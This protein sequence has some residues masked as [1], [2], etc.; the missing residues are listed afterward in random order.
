[1][2]SRLYGLFEEALGKP[3][4]EATWQEVV[5]VRPQVHAMIAE[6]AESI[7]LVKTHNLLGHIMEVPTINLPVSAGSIYVVRNPLDVV[8]SLSDHLGMTIEGAIAVMNHHAHRTLNAPE[9]AF[10]VW[11]TWSEHVESW[12]GT[13]SPAALVLRYEDLLEDP[14]K[15]FTSI[16][17]HLGQRPPAEQIAEAVELSSFER[18]RDQEAEKGFREVSSMATASSGSAA[19]ASGAMR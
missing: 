15:H 11:G 6:R 9:E 14:I 1:M 7:V 18:L 19:P 13:P 8:I 10:E 4:Q 12:A 5:P 2:K 3:L 17:H 16:A